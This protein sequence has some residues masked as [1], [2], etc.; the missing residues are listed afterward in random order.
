MW[1]QC[2]VFD[3]RNYIIENSTRKQRGF[4]S[5]IKI[6]SEKV[7]GDNVDF[8]TSKIRLKKVPGN[9][10]DFLISE[11]TSKKYKE[12]TWKFVQI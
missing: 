3:H 2:G 11:I 6:T 4:S 7:R 5:T 9:D 12:M 1:K 8:S 10:V